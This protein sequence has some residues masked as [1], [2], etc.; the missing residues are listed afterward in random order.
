M[1]SKKIINLPEM[2]VK[3]DHKVSLNDF[4]T[5]YEGEALDKEKATGLENESLAEMMKMQ[6]ELYAENRYSILIVLQAMDTAGKDGIIKHVISG[7]NPT[8]VRV[9]SF[10]T[11]S[12][13]EL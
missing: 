6:D 11:P 4:A 5:K 3:P 2:I 9:A 1:A 7:L 8:G 13:R 10:K 12:A